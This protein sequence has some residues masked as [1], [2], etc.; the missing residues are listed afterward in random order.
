MGPHGETQVADWGLACTL[1]QAAAGGVVGTA[2]FMAPEVADGKPASPHSDIYSIGATLVVVLHAVEAASGADLKRLAAALPLEL[3]AI[4]DR[5]LAKEP[6]RRYPDAAALAEDLSA[7]IDGRRVAA[8]SYSAWQLLGRLVRTFRVALIV[9]AVALLVVA[10]VAWQGYRRTVSQR[11]RAILAEESAR[12]AQSQAESAQRAAQQ[13][14][15]GAYVQAAESAEG[16]GA[17]PEAETLAAAVVA[18]SDAFPAA[19][20]ILAR[21][22]EGSEVALISDIALPQCRRLRLASDGK[23]LLCIKDDAVL[24]LRGDDGSLRWSRPGAYYEGVISSAAERVLLVDRDYKGTILDLAT[25]ATTRSGFLVPGLGLILAQRGT[26]WSAAAN[27]RELLLMDLAKGAS[28]TFRP[29]CSGQD[30]MVAL[31]FSA[32]PAALRG[33]CRSG[34]LLRIEAGRDPIE[35]GAAVPGPIQYEPSALAVTSAG[36][37]LVGALDGRLW[38]DGHE[39]QA[40][41]GGVHRLQP[42]VESL[43]VGPEGAVAAVGEGLGPA[44]WFQLGQKPV[45]LPIGDRQ[46]GVFVDGRTLVVAG[47][48]LRRYELRQP[49]HP[50]RFVASS[51]LSQAAVSPDS[52]F[53]AAGGGDGTVT[54]WHS[55]NG[56]VAARLKLTTGV[57]KSVS[58]SP[59]GERLAVG[60]AADNGFAQLQVGSWQ[61]LPVPKSGWI[62]QLGYF[63]NGVLWRSLYNNG[64][65]ILD[66]QGAVHPHACLPSEC[67]QG[68]VAA[69]A[70]QTALIH[71]RYKGE[72]ML[73][74]QEDPLH[75]EFLLQAS[76]ISAIALSADQRTVAVAEAARIRILDVASRRFVREIADPG[77]SIL[78]VA[79][80]PDDRLLF[81]GE[82]DRTVR[83][84]RLADGVELAVL[85]GHSQRVVQVAFGP[86]SLGLLTTSWDATVRRWDLSRLVAPS[87]TVTALIAAQWG[88]QVEEVLRSSVR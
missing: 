2:G 25:G 16:S 87:N 13:H 31:A 53:V 54:I 24:L 60:L 28:L 73:L 64:F 5:C 63:A 23:W 55:G 69:N 7:W 21:R 51:G 34:R 32:E 67:S 79:F 56:S 33:L 74:R 59:N 6:L 57:V 76:W 42:S 85:R 22:T 50:V 35:L 3:A 82:L 40:W 20:G 71:A 65:D 43:W 1:E 36:Q 39:L 8:H 52:R 75:A 37:T 10:V 41:S 84:W 26:A 9:G 83:V 14:L 68:L 66:A 46:A 15:A 11:D 45:R 86:G 58:F 30:S 12:T 19:R 72:L 88:L 4:A 18:I 29:V 77:Q 80:S 17:H 62:K 38:V 49:V 47:E 27:T 48:R 44:V 61:A 78:H 81:A 70:T